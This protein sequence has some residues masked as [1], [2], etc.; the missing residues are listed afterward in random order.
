[1]PYIHK[2]KRSTVPT[3]RATHAAKGLGPR[4]S[5][6]RVAEILLA[7]VFLFAAIPKLAGVHTS[8]QM[9][10][11][12]GA[13]QWLRYFVGI[14][15]AAGAIGLFV[16]RLAGLAAAGLATDM[17]GASVINVVVLSSGGVVVTVLL[18]IGCV[19]VARHR[20]AQMKSLA[21][22]LERTS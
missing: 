20:F 21:A 9:F 6:W 15:E 18:C 8:V 4:R 2:P 3:A 13:G 1:M 12:I 7:V 5:A 10:D 19:L 16:P 11:Q 22:D 14:A 17:F